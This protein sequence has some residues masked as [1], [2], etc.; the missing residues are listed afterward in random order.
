MEQEHEK[1]LARVK[2]EI[3]KLR[4]TGNQKI[5][6]LEEEKH[7]LEKAATYSSEQ[8]EILT[9]EKVGGIP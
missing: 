8:V 5:K 7:T 1:E 2:E 3:G 9:D 6:Q 4:E